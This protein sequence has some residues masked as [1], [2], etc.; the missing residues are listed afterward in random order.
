[1]KRNDLVQDFFDQWHD[2]QLGE[3][4][5][6]MFNK[7]YN[8]LSSS[9]FPPDQIFDDLRRF[10]SQS[11]LPSEAEQAAITTVLAYFFFRC[12]IFKDPTLRELP[13]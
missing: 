6:Q 2:P 13:T 9:G 10:A 12:D 1:M 4:I 5:A 11:D 8:E 3:K 7:R